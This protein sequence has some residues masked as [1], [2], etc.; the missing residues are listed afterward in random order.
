MVITTARSVYSK[1]LLLQIQKKIENEGK[2]GAKF[3]IQ[4]M[5][6]F[7][8]L[9][10]FLVANSNVENA[11]FSGA[12][13]TGIDLSEADFSE[14]NF[15]YANLRGANFSGTNLSRADFE[16]ADLSG[17]DF[18]Y[19]N[20]SEANLRYANLS[21]AN[22][23]CTLLK[24]ANFS[25]ANLSGALLFLT[26]LREVLNLEPL[27]LKAKPSPFLCN[28][29]L[30]CYSQQPNIN[31]NRACNLIPQLWRE[32]YKISLHEAQWIVNEAL[33]YQWD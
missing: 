33:Q 31:P 6:K 5:Q 23:N 21:H 16:Y 17:A 2:K 14:A 24:K 15:R 4:S 18:R 30:P 13:L 12:D 19:A 1:G 29:A 3:L 26:N 25:D 20:L 28:V 8:F 22:L 7:D 32:R 11:D 10:N 9:N 27:Q